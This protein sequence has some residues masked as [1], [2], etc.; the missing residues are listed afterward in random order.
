MPHL[1]SAKKRLKQNIIRN[2]RNKA[3]KSALKTQIKKFLGLLNAQNTQAAEEELRLTVKK[4]DKSVA[5]GILC[6]NNASR[7]KSRLTKKLNQIK[8]GAQQKS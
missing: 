8:T 7:K 6:K 4:I 3:Y 5:K 1:A 2:T